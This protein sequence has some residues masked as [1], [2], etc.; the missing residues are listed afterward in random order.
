M[1][2]PPAAAPERAYRPDIDGLRAI[3]I[4]SVVLYHS[5]LMR[6]NGGFTGVDI[7]FVISGYLIGGQIWTALRAGEFSYRRF[8][9][10]R[11]KRILPAFYAVIVFALGAGWLLLSPFELELLARSAFAAVLSGSNILFWGTTN[12]F[13]GASERYPLLMTWSLGVEEQFYLVIPLLMALVARVRRQWILP[14]IATVCL[15]SFVLAALAVDHHPTAVFYLLPMRAWELGAGLVLALCETE[16]KPWRFASGLREAAGFAALWLMAAPMFALRAETTASAWTVLPAVA[17]AALAIAVPGSWINRRWLSAGPMRFIGKISYSWYLWHWP[18]LSLMHVLY[19]GAVPRAREVETVALSFVAA[20]ASYFLIEQPFRRSTQPVGQM[21]VRYGLASAAL[22]GICAAFW[23][24]R[25]VPRRCPALVAMEN[26]G[27]ALRSDP[28]LAGLNSD[29]PNLSPTC[30]GARGDR[31]LV[32]LWGDSH[33]AAMAPGLHELARTE[34]YGFVQLGKA[35]CPPLIGTTHFIPR[36]PQLAQG[37]WRF[38]NE[39]LLQLRADTRIRIVVLSAA[40]SAPFYRDWENGWLTADLAHGQEMPTAQATNTLFVD[41]LRATIASLQ[42]AGK[43]VIVLE[44]VPEFAIDPLWRVKAQFIPARRRLTLW[45]GIANAEDPGIDAIDSNPNIALSRFLVEQT[46]AQFKRVD[47]VD[48]KLAL[49]RGSGQCVYRDGGR[50][51]Y[52]DSS[53]LSRDGALY[54][55]RNF[56]LP[57]IGA[58]ESAAR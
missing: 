54:A 40:W 51:L 18:L 43:Q 31:P 56:R 55:L 44:D 16:F 8:Y 41:S 23:L 28:C 35:S 29:E 57:A 26:P 2:A 20:V 38:N 37:C 12:Y 27:R 52:I 6:L 42:A 46:A 4:L 10:R 5:G 24:T 33:A 7:F 32:A 17:G 39:V 15:G 14:A 30:Y 9:Q 25:G 50:L 48:P 13:A 49:C 34:G 1:S 21:L 11:A 47:L 58:R 19:D 22:A 53:H 45:L 36:V 3:A